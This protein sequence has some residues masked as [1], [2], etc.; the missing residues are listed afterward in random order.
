VPIVL[1]HRIHVYNIIIVYVSARDG[2]VLRI[3]G[4]VDNIRPVAWFNICG[5]KN[6]AEKV[7]MIHN[8]VG[9]WAERN[10]SILAI[11][12]RNNIILCSLAQYHHI[13]CSCPSQYPSLQTAICCLK[14][15][16]LYYYHYHYKILS[17]MRLNLTNRKHS[18]TR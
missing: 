17:G 2:H 5:F 4:N 13:I 9:V 15:V 7:I 12:R 1:K 11:S 14:I 18:Y 16:L 10:K 6:N 3:F 8:F